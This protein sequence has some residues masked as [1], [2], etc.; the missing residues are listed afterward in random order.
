MGCWK[1]LSKNTGIAECLQATRP[2][3]AI[4]SVS[5]LEIREQTRTQWTLIVGNAWRHCR[6]GRGMSCRTN[7]KKVSLI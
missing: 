7:G 6:V 4:D 3:T 1:L 2:T 5:G